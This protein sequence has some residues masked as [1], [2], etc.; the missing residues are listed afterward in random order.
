MTNNQNSNRDNT[1]RYKL[2]D[3]AE[4]ETS[5]K[6]HLHN[7]YTV[8]NDYRIWFR[9]LL[10]SNVTYNIERQ[11]EDNSVVTVKRYTHLP[12]GE[13]SAF[14]KVRNEN[15][16]V[17][18]FTF[19][20]GERSDFPGK[21]IHAK[22]IYDDSIKTFTLQKLDNEDIDYAVVVRIYYDSKYSD[23]LSQ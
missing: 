11:K 21:T 6:I 20:F 9:G 7:E 15:I 22:V 1:Y 10:V 8:P 13:K 5:V 16:Y 19:T 12:K 4:K 2:G 23:E 3:F 18:E 14:E 17:S